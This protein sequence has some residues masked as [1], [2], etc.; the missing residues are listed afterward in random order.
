MAELSRDVLVDRLRIDL[1]GPSEPDEVLKAR[2]SDVYLT[3]ILY[4]RQTPFGQE[5]EE[6][7][8]TESGVGEGSSDSEQSPVERSTRPS[9]AGLSFAAKGEGA[10]PKVRVRISC[11]RYE[12]S[13]SAQISDPVLQD[14]APRR[15]QR[16]TAWRRRGFDIVVPV[17]LDGGPHTL[18]LASYGIDK[19]S[20]Y[21]QHSV[22]KDTR[23]ATVVLINEDE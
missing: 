1:I 4:P 16:A 20:L 3:G 19:S 8:A 13:D 11:A 23:L 22:W 12:P 21:V 15:H 6:T 14:G 2:P 17:V 5:E 7:L 9:A 10:S 18:G